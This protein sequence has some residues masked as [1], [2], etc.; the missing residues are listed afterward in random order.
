MVGEA[1]RTDVPRGDRATL[2]VVAQVDVEVVHF[3]KRVVVRIGPRMERG[4][5]CGIEPDVIAAL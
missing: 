1:V 3:A 2:A 4:V 5:A